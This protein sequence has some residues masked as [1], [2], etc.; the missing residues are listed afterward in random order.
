MFNEITNTNHENTTKVFI[1]HDWNLFCLQSLFKKSVAEMEIPNYLEGIII[2]SDK[3][4][5]NPFKQAHF[6]KNF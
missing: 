1:T 6:I 5:F 4:T 2:S 3:K